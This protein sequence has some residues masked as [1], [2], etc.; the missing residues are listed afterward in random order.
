MLP[1]LTQTVVALGQGNRLVGITDFDELDSSFKK[2]PR[3]GGFLN[4]GLEAI[5]A[6]KPDMVLLGNMQTELQQKLSHLHIPSLIFAQQSVDDVFDGIR[7]LGEMLDAPKSSDSLRKSMHAGLDSIAALSNALHRPSC[8][9]VI[10][11]NPG[12]LQNLFTCGPASFLAQLLSVAGGESVFADMKQTWAPISLE[13]IILR[14]PEVILDL[15]GNSV[16]DSKTWESLESVR[17]VKSHRIYMLDQKWMT[18]PGPMMVEIAGTF[19][20]AIHSPGDAK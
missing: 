7:I 11:R 10:S 19:F 4:P 2:I 3:L 17:A 16:G 15:S 20:Q 8:L 6:L 14:N 1:S 12:T 13:E 18:L 9:L 5:L